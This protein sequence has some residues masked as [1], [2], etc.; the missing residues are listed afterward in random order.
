MK[1]IDVATVSGAL[2]FAV[3]VVSAATPFDGMWKTGYFKPAPDGWSKDCPV[4]VYA[5]VTI[6]LH[7]AVGSGIRYTGGMLQGQTMMTQGKP[8][9]EIKDAKGKFLAAQ[10]KQ[11]TL[12]T[13]ARGDG[14]LA[15]VA[16]S[17]DCKP[18]Y[19]YCKA[20]PYPGVFKVGAPDFETTFVLDNN[21]QLRDTFGTDDK[22]DD[23]VYLQSS[24]W[25]K[26]S[27]RGSDTSN[28]VV[29]LLV[30]KSC[31]DVPALIAAAWSQY[32]NMSKD[33]CVATNVAMGHNPTYREINRQFNPS[34]PGLPYNQWMFQ[35]VVKS[36]SGQGTL[37]IAL[38]EEQPNQIRVLQWLL[39]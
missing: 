27:A 28:R 9:C 12:E 16:H 24:E 31:D 4:A 35:Y 30:S 14:T 13:K 22:G 8:G 33:T 29:K 26:Q 10:I 38:D 7:P 15:V 36:D 21:G 34:R 18:D 25:D 20:S 1:M 3:G 5:E 2:L 39:R 6:E 23:L 37:L 32:K 11:W 17:G 19:D